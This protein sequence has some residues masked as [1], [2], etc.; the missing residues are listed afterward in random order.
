MRAC[1]VVASMALVR[2]TV[3]AATARVVGI[4]VATAA[5]AT[6]IAAIRV[7]SIVV[8]GAITVA[9]IVGTVFALTWH[10]ER[11]F[12]SLSLHVALDVAHCFGSGCHAGIFEMINPIRWVSV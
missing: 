1:L 5:I 8:T 12:G 11:C 7:A 9:I 10:I 6:A 3:A 2:V 4:A